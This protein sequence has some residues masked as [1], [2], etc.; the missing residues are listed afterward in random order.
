[1]NLGAKVLIKC[2]ESD[3][4]NTDHP[5][6]IIAKAIID[7]HIPSPIAVDMTRNW[8]TMTYYYKGPWS[9]ADVVTVLKQ[10]EVTA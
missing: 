2:W 9:W 4:H 5:A 3:G 8:M 10:Y 7:H 6:Y 1:M